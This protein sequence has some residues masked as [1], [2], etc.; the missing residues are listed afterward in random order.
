MK[1]KIAIVFDQYESERIQCSRINILLLIDV[2]V[3]KMTTLVE[4]NQ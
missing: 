1:E 3:E 4:K 2:K